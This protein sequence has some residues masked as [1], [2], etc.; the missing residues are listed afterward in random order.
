V[1]DIDIM[2]SSRELITQAGVSAEWW[3]LVDV[4]EPV[5]WYGRLLGEQALSARIAG[6]EMPQSR[7]YDA[8][9]SLT[10]V[11]D[12]LLPESMTARAV[13]SLCESELAGERAAAVE[14]GRFAESW[15]A[16]AGQPG[17]LPEL[18][19]SARLLQALGFM[20]VEVL[21]GRVDRTV[22]LATLDAAAEPQGEY[23]I[24]VAPMLRA[25]LLAKAR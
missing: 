20:V 12:G 24:A 9:T 14:L 8:D 16:L 23:L 3:P 6:N 1:S 25:W 22:A 5:K 2:A 19:E 21:A 18:T 7:P 13:A 15:Q 17:C 10:L 4:L 11:I